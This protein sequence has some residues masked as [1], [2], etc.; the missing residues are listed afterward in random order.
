MRSARLLLAICAALLAMTACVPAGSLRPRTQTPE[1]VASNTPLL[2]TEIPPTVR[3]EVLRA[4]T[5]SLKINTPEPPACIAGEE[6][7]WLRDAPEGDKIAALPT[8]TRVQV[9]ARSNWARNG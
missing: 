2:A 3:P 1:P 7:Y 8:G 5:E 4:V 6:G 9:L